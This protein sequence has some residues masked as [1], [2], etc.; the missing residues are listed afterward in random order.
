MLKWREGRRGSK[1]SRGDLWCAGKPLMRVM[2]H[3]HHKNYQCVIRWCDAKIQLLHKH[4]LE[5]LE[6]IGGKEMVDWDDDDE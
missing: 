6:M 3:M 4:A 5:G 2:R 1:K